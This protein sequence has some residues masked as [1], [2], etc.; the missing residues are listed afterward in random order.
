M[1]H[2]SLDQPQHGRMARVGQ[3][4]NPPA[5]IA[6]GRQHVLDEVVA[7]DRVEVG[8]QGVDGDRGGRGLDHDAERRQCCRDTLRRQLGK[9][10]RDDGPRL[11]QL[12]RS[13]H[14][15]QHHLHRPAVG[16]AEEGAELGTEELGML[17]AEPKAAQA[18]EG[19]ALVREADPGQRLV[20]ADVE[21][22]DDRGL[23]VQAVEQAGI[24]PV[25]L[26]LVRQPQAAE[27][28]ELGPHQPDTVGGGQQL[29][30]HSIRAVDVQH[31]LHALA[32]GRDCRLVQEGGGPTIV[33]AAGGKAA[34]VEPAGRRAGV[35]HQDAGLRVEHGLDRNPGDI[36]QACEQRHAAG[37][38]QHGDVR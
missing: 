35:E 34:R 17:E 23:A 3:G 13:G 8:R 26:L 6:R 33:R 32:R 28:E 16:G 31:Q 9:A 30:A 18:Q 1:A 24:G 10:A 29:V 4:R 14:H 19:V 38:R 5:R 27:E 11:R 37:A 21:G 22:A 36:A 7:A 12:V 20:A 2:H 15:R 25:L